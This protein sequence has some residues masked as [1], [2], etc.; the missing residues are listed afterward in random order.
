MVAYNLIDSA[1]KYI[2]LLTKPITNYQ[3]LDKKNSIYKLWIKYN[4][5]LFNSQNEF[6]SLGKTTLCSKSI[7]NNTFVKNYNL[8]KSKINFSRRKNKVRPSLTNCCYIDLERSMQNCYD[9]QQFHKLN[10]LNEEQKSKLVDVK[11]Y[12]D[13]CVIYETQNY[14]ENTDKVLLLMTFVYQ[15]LNEFEN[16]SINVN[17]WNYSLRTLTVSSKYLYLGIITIFS[18]LSW[19]TILA[20]NIITEYNPNFDDLILIVTTL[21]SLISVLYSFDT[22]Q[23]FYNS[24]FFYKFTYTLYNDFPKLYGNKY[25]LYWNFT[26]DFMSNCLIPFIMPFLNFFIVLHSDSVLDAILNSMA[27]FFIIH[28]DEELYTRTT[29]ENETDMKNYVKKIIST[30]YDH[31]TPTF[32]PNFT[33]EYESEH[34]KIFKL[35]CKI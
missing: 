16:K 6:L 4:I 9:I 25:I 17:M 5:E 31:F 21:S 2:D 26:A 3:L 15:Y 35:A 27:I 18:Q 30:L 33:Y 19:L 24:F 8:F 11:K 29:Y 13:Q 1:Y 28:I 32:S 7:F 20:Y 12:I 14:K 10:D 22:I 23:S 34:N